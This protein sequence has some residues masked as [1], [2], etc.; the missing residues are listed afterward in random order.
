MNRAPR[1]SAWIVAQ[2]AERR[3][4]VGGDVHG[5]PFVHQCAPQRGRDAFVIVDYQHAG[6][7]TIS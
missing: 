1:P 3:G 6:H 5:M 4:P 7:L 2:L